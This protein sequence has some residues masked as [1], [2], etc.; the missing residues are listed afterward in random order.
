MALILDKNV[1]GRRCWACAQQIR[2][3][4]VTIVNTGATEIMHMHSSCAQAV[5]RQ[6]LRDLAQLVDLGYEL[7][8]E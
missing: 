7:E 3:D 1:G 6:M 2:S 5:S 8:D 4:E